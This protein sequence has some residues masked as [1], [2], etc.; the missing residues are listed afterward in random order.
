MLRRR[1]LIALGA[2]A[3]LAPL[4]APSAVASTPQVA[5][6]RVTLKA[7]QFTRWELAKTNACGSEQ[8]H[9]VLHLAVHQSRHVTIE[10]IRY[11]DHPA[12]LMFRVVGSRLGIPVKG[13]ETQL[14]TMTYTPNGACTS[15]GNGGAPSGSSPPEP[16]CGVKAYTGNVDPGWSRPKEYPRAPGEARPPTTVFW[17]HEPTSKVAFAVCPYWGAIS[18]FVRTNAALTERTVF[19]ARKRITLHGHLKDVDRTPLVADGVVSKTEIDWTVKL[20][21]LS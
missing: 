12:P 17:L 18:Q 6:F 1:L 3:A 20:T 16:D 15:P 10:L 21:R 7:D 9:G 19:G 2:T 5:R 4:G 14:G 8:G 11:N 13:T